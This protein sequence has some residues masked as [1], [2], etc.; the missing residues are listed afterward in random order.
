MPAVSVVV[1][2]YGVEPY[3]RQCLD[4]ILGQSYRDIEVIAVDDASPDECGKILNEY[5]ARDE[6][7]QVIHLKDNVGLGPARG[8]GFA[9]ATGDY[10]WFVDSDDW[11]AQ[12]A[13]AAVARRIHATPADV[14]FVDVAETRLETGVPVVE[15]VH[16]VGTAEMGGSAF[17]LVDH[18]HVIGNGT[19]WRMIIARDLVR[20][21]GSP[22][23]PGYFEDIPFTFAVLAMAEAIHVVPR[24]CY[25]Y[26]VRRSGSITETLD[27]RV[28][29][30][31]AQYARVFDQLDDFKLPAQHALRELALARLVSQGWD[32]TNWSKIPRPLRRKLLATISLEYRR[33][34]TDR[35]TPTRLKERL[36]HRVIAGNMWHTQCAWRAGSFAKQRFVSWISG[37]AG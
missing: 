36:R 20:R 32:M 27:E 13:I 1:P 8:I 23:Y 6:R 24:I 15:R 12:G 37:A 2:V 33:R 34:R 14:L 11:L 25:H 9:Q 26:R 5:A 7:L 21:A 31:A 29:A 30:F 16:R 10:V 28:L 17:R 18:P 4:S 35:R 22:F 19:V 3:L